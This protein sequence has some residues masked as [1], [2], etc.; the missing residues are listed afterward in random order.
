ME[1]CGIYEQA[2]PICPRDNISGHKIYVKVKSGH[3]LQLSVALVLSS[4]SAIGLWW[5][6]SNYP[7]T[8]GRCDVCVTLINLFQ[9]FPG[10]YHLIRQLCREDE[11]ATANYTMEV[12]E[13]AFVFTGHTGF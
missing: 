4:T 12:H 13:W 11:Q 5:V 9:V 7:G 6:E 2:F 8:Q 1:H 10:T 3:K